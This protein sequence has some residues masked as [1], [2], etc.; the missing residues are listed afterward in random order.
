[1]LIHEGYKVGKH[2]AKIEGHEFKGICS[3]CGIAES[4]EHILTKCDVPGQE[5]VWEMA[6][7]LWKIKTDKELPKPTMGQIMACAATKK[8]ST[9]ETRL[10][11]ILVSESAFLVWRLR[12]ERVIQGKPPASLREIQN[13]W[14]RTMN[15]R[16]KLDCALT[17]AGKYGKKALKKD[18]VIK[19][20]V[21]VLKNE[22]NLPKDWTREAEVLNEAGRRVFTNNHPRG[23]GRRA[24]HDLYSDTTIDD[25]LATRHRQPGHAPWTRA[26]CGVDKEENPRFAKSY[27]VAQAEVPVSDQMVAKLLAFHGFLNYMIGVVRASTFMRELRAANGG[28]LMW[29]EPFAAT[30]IA[31]STA[32]GSEAKQDVTID[33]LDTEGQVLAQGASLCVLTERKTVIN[34]LSDGRVWNFYAVHKR[35]DGHQET[36]RFHAEKVSRLFIMTDLETILGLCV[37]AVLSPAEEFISK[38][39]NGLNE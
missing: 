3:H 24:R 7:E 38:A 31:H 15:V 9:G 19:T 11:R 32:Y 25:A 23:C 16:L 35:P 6:S 2:W 10:F 26:E 29:T 28:P 20:W 17:D 18:L 22:E 36:R 37:I 39:E 4:M 5:R 1:M 14:L 30:S 8:G 12:N 33:T 27:V 34:V 21:K 13:R